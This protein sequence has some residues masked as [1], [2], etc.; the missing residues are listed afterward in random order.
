MASRLHGT[1]RRVPRTQDRAQEESLPKVKRTFYL[2]PSAVIALS[3]LQLD[4]FKRTGKKP[5]LSEL[6]G[7]AIRQLRGPGG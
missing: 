5:D 7:R 3:E 4:E 6:V 1:V 2:E